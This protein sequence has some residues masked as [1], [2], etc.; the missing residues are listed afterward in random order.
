VHSQLQGAPK[1]TVHLYASNNLRS[2]KETVM[3]FDAGEWVVLNRHHVNF[4][5]HRTITMATS[6]AFM[7][8]S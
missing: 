5:L 7:H 2:A 3:K 1:I 4:H 6:H 8:T